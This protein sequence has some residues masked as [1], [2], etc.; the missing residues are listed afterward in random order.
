[1]SFRLKTILGIA[2]IEAILLAFLIFNIL[3]YLRDSNEKQLVE[4]VS[5]SAM[6]FATAAKDAVIS[7]DLATL[8]SILEAV[9]KNPGIEYA[10]ILDQN[11]RILAEQGSKQALSRYFKENQGSHTVIDGIYN[12]QQLIIEGNYTY[13]TVQLG[14][15][16][17]DLQK[18][19]NDAQRNSITIALIEMILVALFSTFLGIY[20]TGQLKRLTEASELVASGKLGYQLDVKGNDEIAKTLCAFN[21]MSAK[22]KLYVDK[23]EQ[24]QHE[25]LIAKTDAETANEAKSSFLSNMS[26]ELRTPLNAVIG[27]SEILQMEKHSSETSSALHE[28]NT[29]G[30][31]LLSLVNQILELSQIDQGNF[32]LS[33]EDISL[34]TIINECAKYVLPL[35]TKNNI[36]L[37]I[38][39]HYP[40]LT[41]TANELRLKQSLINLFSN[42]I[43]YNKKDGHV[44]I[45]V[46]PIDD[47]RC[48]I[49]VKDTGIGIPPH[50]IGELF[51]PFHR[52][53]EK[54]Y[55]VQGAG[56]GLSITK[57]LIELMHGTISVNSEVNKGTE[58]TVILALGHNSINTQENEQEPYK[59][60]VKAADMPTT[61]ANITDKNADSRATT[62]PSATTETAV[63]EL[64][65]TAQAE[66]TNKP[67]TTDNP[68]STMNTIKQKNTTIV[69]VEDNPANLRL[70]EKLIARKD[71][72][73]LKSATTGKQGL[74]LCIDEKPQFIMLDI[75]LPD[76]NGT[77]ILKTLREQ[78]GMQNIPCIAITA[79]AMQSDTD[80]FI[81]AGFD[82]VLTKPIDVDV[83]YS[84]LDKYLK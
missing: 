41:V 67:D 37:T 49:A 83:F 36:S 80:M 52:L 24:T 45:T 78:H 74:Q 44:D 56:I 55:D 28:I 10:R 66:D 30:K 23:I 68:E 16:I 31:H 38:N 27:F 50:E 13:G 1:M 39:N 70:I 48:M 64:P 58:F 5:T 72:L 59:P 53:N 71:N 4:R 54:N 65:F 76:I 8:E 33:L 11:E 77:E 20:L 57:N 18:T 63:T 69:Y 84:T 43:Q 9:M 7:Y 22:V 60:A 40:L 29:A 17:Q 32:D 51:K 35:Q 25:L 79:N 42:A 34:H 47:K 26:H 14:F 19:L 81:A 75:N 46:E 61:L 82:E 6:L 73:V 3:N 2:I 62:L 15:D 21:D 12:T